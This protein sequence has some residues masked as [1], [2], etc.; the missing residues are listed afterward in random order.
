[1]YVK[2]VN[3]NINKIQPRYIRFQKLFISKTK[4]QH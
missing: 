2:Q 3:K 4:T 1:M